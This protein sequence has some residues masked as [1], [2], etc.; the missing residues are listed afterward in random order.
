M[1]HI[2]DLGRGKQNRWKARYRAPDGRERSKTF[3]VKADAERFLAEVGV[4]KARGQWTDPRKAKVPFETFAAEFLEAKK[5]SVRPAT[6]SKYESALKH[7]VK[8]FGSTP[9]GKVARSDVQAFIRKMSETY[10]PATVR[11]A[12]TLLG[13]IMNEAIEEGSSLRV[14]A[15]TSSFPAWR[16]SSDVS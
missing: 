5:L 12:Y 6:Q 3:R 7:L 15:A 9:I 16:R 10:A 14:H 11:I 13:M 4:A 1:G 8:A 2:R